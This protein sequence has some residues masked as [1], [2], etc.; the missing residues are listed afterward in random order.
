M[1]DRKTIAFEGREYFD[2]CLYVLTVCP[3]RTHTNSEGLI[4]MTFLKEIST[5]LI[6]TGLLK[7]DDGLSGQTGAL[8]IN[9]DSGC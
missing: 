2:D 6:S 7:D 1:D 8:S 3:G 4:C 5:L 9:Y